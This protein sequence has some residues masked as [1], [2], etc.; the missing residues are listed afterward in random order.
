MAQVPAPTFAA[1][2]KALRG[3]MAQ[4]IEMF[5]RLADPLLQVTRRKGRIKWANQA[6][7]ELLGENLQDRRIKEVFASKDLHTALKQLRKGEISQRDLIVSA[8]NFP[9]RDFRA[10]LVGLER[11]TFYGARV[12]IS[13]TEITEVMRLQRQRADFVANASHELKTPIASLSGFIET[14]EQ[15]PRA[16]ETFLPLMSTEAARMRALIRDLLSLTRTEMEEGKL[17]EQAQLLEPLMDQA[18]QSMQPNMERRLQK[19]N[20]VPMPPKA[21]V[22]A[23]A[24][25]L[26][27][28]FINLLQN[29]SK[30]APDATPIEIEPEIE[31][32]S[33][34]IHFRNEGKGIEAK[35]IPRLTERFYRIDD[36][37]ARKEGGTGLGLAIVKHVLIRH[38][39][40][41]R[42]A[43]APDE[44]ATFTVVLPL[45]QTSETSKS[46]P[47]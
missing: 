43:S 35:H 47:E 17:P 45:H 8:K 15:D 14:L 32:N 10:R 21:L 22:R 9:D 33:L 6:A 39:G 3:Q 30:Y 16:L 5:D 41:L 38:G 1:K 23:D 18:V 26:T 44:G 11:K 19:L 24:T 25:A 2:R 7:A 20:R 37:R 28:V 46:H 4:Q 34:L 31:G 40:E 27:T 29:A 42:I 36:S 12:L 13:L